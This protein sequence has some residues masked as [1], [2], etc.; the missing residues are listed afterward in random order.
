MQ[1]IIIRAQQNEKKGHTVKHHRVSPSVASRQ[2][3]PNARASHGQ[4]PQGV[5]SLRHVREKSRD[6]VGQNAATQCFGKC[7]AML[8]KKSSLSSSLK[9]E[10]EDKSSL[11][12]R[13]ARRTV[14]FLWRPSHLQKWKMDNPVKH[15]Q[16]PQGVS[17][18]TY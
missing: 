5:S 14:A 16:T 6:Q 10:N 12:K 1:P 4:T 17:N 2:K 18:A 15:G 9:N 3:S 7:K 11:E 8:R 13:W